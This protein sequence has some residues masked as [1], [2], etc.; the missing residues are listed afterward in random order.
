MKIDI[1]SNEVEFSYTKRQSMLT[2][3]SAGTFQDL[4]VE[5]RRVFNKWYSNN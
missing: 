3:F 5:E 2:S 1:V 4:L